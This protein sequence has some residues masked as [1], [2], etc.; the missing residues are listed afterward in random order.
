MFTRPRYQLGF[1]TRKRRSR[2]DD[3]WEFRYYES[4]AT[5]VRIRRTVTV[6]SVAA[7]PRRSDALA[8]IH[9]LRLRINGD[10]GKREPVTVASL[11]KKKVQAGR[12]QS[13]REP[14][15]SDVL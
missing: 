3:V 9:T 5:G 6:G 2:G 15:R 14:P 8:R 12:H 4:N 11:V 7:Y 1:L 13:N 10:L